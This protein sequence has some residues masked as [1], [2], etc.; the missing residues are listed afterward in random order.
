MIEAAGQL[1]ALW[2]WGDGQRGHPRLVRTSA[3]FHHPVL[4]VTSGLRLRTVVRRKRRLFLGTTQIFADETLVATVDAV[5]V[6]LPY[7]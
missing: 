7:G 5:W 3:E 4:P 6:V 2:T 1:V